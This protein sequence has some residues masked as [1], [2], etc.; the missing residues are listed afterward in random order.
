MKFLRFTNSSSLSSGSLD[1]TVLNTPLLPLHMP[2][3]SISA[4]ADTIAQVEAFE[5]LGD[6]WDG[7]GA[8][9]I[10]KP[11]IRN[12]SD[13]VESFN[14][15]SSILTPVVTPH[16]NGIIT[17]EWESLWG[18]AYLEIGQTQCCFYI[19][20]NIGETIYW[21]GSSGGIINFADSF[22]RILQGLIFPSLPG[23]HAA[24]VLA[25][26]AAQ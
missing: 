10:E 3:I 18:E 12:A 5:K 24:S 13:L 4:S 6:N 11:T 17:F 9:S 23:R 26:N 14:W 15:P 19:R 21:T 20:P 16:P 7:H 25:P 8:L 1:A 22:S 2:Q